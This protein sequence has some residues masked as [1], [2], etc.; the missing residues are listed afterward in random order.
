[1]VRSPPRGRQYADYLRPERRG[2]DAEDYG[3]CRRVQ[4]PG[5]PFSSSPNRRLLLERPRHRTSR[6]CWTV[7]ASLSNELCLGVGISDKGHVL[8][9]TA[10]VASFAVA[11]GTTSIDSHRDCSL[12][13]NPL[14]RDTSLLSSPRCPLRHLTHHTGAECAL[15]LQLPSTA[16][17]LGDLRKHRQGTPPRF[18]LG[19]PTPQ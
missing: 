10:S 9:F 7:D 11:S 18:A 4:A 6:H 13:A 1:M 3:P 19:P 5:E 14:R 15:R 17:Q 12:R 8:H 16:G 2:C